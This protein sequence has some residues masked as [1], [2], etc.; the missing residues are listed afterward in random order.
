LR[1]A[2]VGPIAKLA[3][4]PDGRVLAALTEPPVGQQDAGGGV[5]RLWVTGN[6]DSN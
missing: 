5:I 1:L 6:W 2:H 4:S 3:F